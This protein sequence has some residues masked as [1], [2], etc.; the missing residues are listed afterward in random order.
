MYKIY[1]G[2]NYGV[3]SL[4]KN[5]PMGFFE[6][7]LLRS[8][9]LLDYMKKHTKV[10]YVRIS[11]R[12]PANTK[13]PE[14]NE[15]VRR[16]IEAIVRSYQR[17]KT[18]LKYLWVRERKSSVNSHYHLMLLFNGKYVQRPHGVLEKATA[19]WEIQVGGDGQGLVQLEAGK[20]AINLIRHSHDYDANYNEAFRLASYLAKVR[21]KEVGPGKPRMFGASQIP[22]CNR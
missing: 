21:S 1:T 19:L 17:N 16:F 10:C 4:K 14:D 5:E 18:E 12:F 7:L 22:Q 11:L 6:I 2:D 9:D 15:C 20:R 13:Y 8:K 3:L